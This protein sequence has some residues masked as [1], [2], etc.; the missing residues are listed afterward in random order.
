MLVGYG[1]SLTE[2]VCVDIFSA[3]IGTRMPVVAFFLVHSSTSPIPNIEKNNKE[4][5]GLE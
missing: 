3:S 1:G 5:S 4:W 2:K